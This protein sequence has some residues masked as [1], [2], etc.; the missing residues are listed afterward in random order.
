MRGTRLEK[1]SDKN[2]HG[3]SKYRKEFWKETEGIP[4]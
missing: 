2:K 1:L 3:V 4:C